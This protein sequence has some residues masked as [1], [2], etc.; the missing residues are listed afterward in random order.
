MSISYVRSFRRS[1]IGGVAIAALVP[2]FAM[3]QESAGAA[4]E[5][6]ASSSEEIVVTGTMVR[7]VAPPGANPISVS[8]QA[9]QN[10]G[11]TS[12]NQ[13]L[14]TVPQLASFGNLQQPLAASPEVSVNRP[15]LRN[16]PGF[17]NAGGSTTL[18]LMDGHR[19]VG[20][21][22]ATT[23]PDPDVIPPS[24]I[25]RIE[26][27]PDGGSAI[28]GS[29][30]VAGVLNF[31]TRKRFDG[32]KVDAS[33]G[34]ADNYYSWDANILAGKDWGSGSLFV[35]Y[36]YA[37]SDEL[38]GGERDYIREFPSA[39]YSGVLARQLYCPGA[40]NFTYGSG[41]TAVVNRVGP[42][43]TFTANAVNDCDGS[44][45][46]TVFPSSQRHSVFA[47]LTQELDDNT[48]ID[49]RAYYT[50]R[51]TQI[52]TGDYTYQ[53]A[54]SS[55]NNAPAPYNDPLNP[56]DNVQTV[57]G[58]FGPR[59]AATADIAISTW[60]VTPTITRKLGDNFQLR[61]LYSYGES[62]NRFITHS[63]NPAAVS[64]A[65]GF[66]LFDP[67]RPDL[68]SP[69]VLGAFTNFENF[70]HTR[71]SFHN[72]RA[73]VDGDLFEMSGG[74]VKMAAGV[75]YMSESFRSN[76]GN[77]IPGFENTGYVNGGP[78]DVIPDLAALPR[79]NLSRNVKSVF[80]EVI[81]P[82]FGSGN[83]TP[84]IEELTV[85][86]AGRYDKYSDFGDTF[87]PRIGVTYKPFGWL[88]LRGAWGKSFNAPSL[89]DDDA[90]TGSTVFLLPCNA[91]G[92]CPPSDLV[93]NG[94]YPAQLPGQG[95]IVAVRG[96]APGIE[97]QTA[98]TWTLGFEARP[99]TGFSFGVTYFNINF[100]NIIG[101]APFENGGTLYRDFGQVINDNP[102]QAEIDAIY[103]LW[104][105]PGNS[106]GRC[107]GT[108][109]VAN[110]YAVVD[111]RK[112]N[113]GSV[114]VS[115]LDF[116]LNYRYETGFGALFF[117]TNGT[118]TLSN[119]RSSSAGR[120]FVEQVNFN[121]TKLRMRTTV[122]A[123]VGPVTG[124]LVWNH[125]SGYPLFPTVGVAG[126]A[127]T[128]Q[129]MV[130]SFNTFD[131]LLRYD[132]KGEGF[133]KDLSL[134]LNVNNLFDAAPPTYIAFD[135]VAGRRG[136]ANGATLGRFVQFGVSKKF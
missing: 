25:E 111:A 49:I 67:Y 62:D 44:D 53:F 114:K 66:G 16:L 123:D 4:G 124:Q 71:Q 100:R 86:L 69:A 74:A 110:T 129:T 91:I 87:N 1:I 73:V 26:I 70:N 109:T 10:I 136:T 56:N 14:Q 47:G 134:R 40:A 132:M 75:E 48:S 83:A 41:S 96:N 55:Q 82:F 50:R 119:K 23:S 28:Y 95:N 104:S 42:G 37:K 112:N 68:A 32:V 3:A 98:T 118:Y 78:T 63:V 85:S 57:F 7:G 115:G 121:S 126:F 54:Y 36:S 120:P 59:G 64:R 79:F 35:A 77:A 130:S 18:V 45:Y 103:N 17:N 125:Q 65:V 5:T 89:A 105:L 60:G 131:L 97:P 33:Y 93:A 30:A 72:V 6:D 102:T 11:A 99:V 80:G 39:N 43:G 52:R 51:T 117:G 13:V 94:Q 92:L 108:P 9:I 107:F 116:N 2:A 128:P 46:A 27:V 122:G 8:T 19:L 24:V 101:L 135:N 88:S 15:N 90:A 20:V 58:S 133:G 12:I 31:I 34:F 29:D 22:V 113:L 106:C 76:Y 127:L 21:G 61:V 81:V 38:L 84:G